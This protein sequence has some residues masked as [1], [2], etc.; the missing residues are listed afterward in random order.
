M[1]ENTFDPAAWL[2]EAGDLGFDMQAC[3]DVEGY[4][5]GIYLSEPDAT[6]ARQ[7]RA[8]ET[9][10]IHHLRTH[11][12]SIR[13]HLIASGRFYVA[14]PEFRARPEQVEG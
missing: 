10:M 8:R 7:N 3:I 12:A 14:S 4:P 13:E 5:L 2:D 11:K 9:D 1:S 6:I